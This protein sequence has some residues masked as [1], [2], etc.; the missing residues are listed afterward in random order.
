MY[1]R[2]YVLL[3]LVQLSFLALVISV[4]QLTHEIQLASI[5]FIAVTLSLYIYER[6]EVI[7]SRNR[8]IEKDI[9]K[10]FQKKQKAVQKTQK[11]SNDVFMLDPR[12]QVQR[13]AS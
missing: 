8:K 2:Q 13:K 12:H 5:L 3:F 1:D 7:M 10:L 9:H 4:P 11:V 6:Q